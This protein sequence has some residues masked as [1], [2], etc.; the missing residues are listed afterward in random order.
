MKTIYLSELFSKLSKN[1]YVLLVLILG[2]VLILLPS[3]ENKSDAE[4][5]GNADPLE[6]TGVSLERE[7]QK[8]SNLLG[9]I[10]G[11]GS[12]HV[13]LSKNGAVI[14]CDG[15]DSAAV[16]LSVTNAVTAYTGLGSD[17][18]WVMKMK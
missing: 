6:V 17:K 16:R 4:A 7:G 15:A 1:K 3:E 2:L 8:L 10:K 9:Q 12:A 11:V 18:I 14:V 13:L 5:D